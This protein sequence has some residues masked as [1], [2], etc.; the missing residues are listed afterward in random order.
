[1]IVAVD[2]SL[3]LVRKWEF[4]AVAGAL[5]RSEVRSASE[6][7]VTVF[8]MSPTFPPE[9]V[10]LT[11]A[12]I[13]P[14]IQPWVIRLFVATVAAAGIGNYAT[15]REY[16]SR[17]V[18]VTGF[19]TISPPRWSS[20]ERCSITPVNSPMR[21]ATSRPWSCSRTMRWAVAI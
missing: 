13:E 14:M 5:S 7:A 15:V 17:G 9:V 2:S 20:P 3:L 6:F 18:A 1:M 4:H 10:T 12:G 16:E 19:L 21:R 8:V 11:V